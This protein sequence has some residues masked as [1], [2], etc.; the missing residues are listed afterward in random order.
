MSDTPEITGIPP[1]IVLLAEMEAL[2]LQMRELKDELKSSFK[3]M[4]IEQLNERQV[5]GS[6]FARGNEILEKVEALLEKVSQ[7]SAMAQV[8]VFSA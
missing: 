1:D 5:G 2:K 3:S 4:L 7:V 8:P 6:G